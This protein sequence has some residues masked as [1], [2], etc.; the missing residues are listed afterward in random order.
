MSKSRRHYTGAEKVAICAVT[1]WNACRSRTYATSRASACLRCTIG[2]TSS[3]RT[4]LPRSS[5]IGGHS[6]KTRCA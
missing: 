1:W 3:F 6:R 2:R 4:V 5:M